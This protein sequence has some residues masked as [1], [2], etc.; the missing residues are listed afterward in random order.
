MNIKE[1]AMGKAAVAVGKQYANNISKAIK[2]EGGIDL[3]IGNK[4]EK[5]NPVDW[6]N[7][8]YPP[9]IRLYHF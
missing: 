6:H 4:Q 1:A 9:M 5:I 3:G 7:Y 2:G 8:N